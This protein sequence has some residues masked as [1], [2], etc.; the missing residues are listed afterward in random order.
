[1]SLKKQTSCIIYCNWSTG[2]GIW[3]EHLHWFVNTQ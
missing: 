1:M 3:N 2:I